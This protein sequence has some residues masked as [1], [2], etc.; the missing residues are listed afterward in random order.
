MAE[1]QDSLNTEYFPD[2]DY[3]SDLWSVEDF[4]QEIQNT[5]PSLWE[6]VGLY[7]IRE[8]QTIYNE[9][10]GKT[11]K[12][13]P[14]RWDEKTRQRLEDN[15][16]EKTRFILDNVI[17][18]HPEYG[19]AWKEKSLEHYMPEF[20]EG[21]GERFKYSAAEPLKDIKSAY[22]Y[23]TIAGAATRLG[24]KTYD[25]LEK[26]SLLLDPVEDP[27]KIE[28]FETE[29][30]VNKD[31]RDKTKKFIELK[32]KEENDRN[33]AKWLESVNR[34]YEDYAVKEIQKRAKEKE[35]DPR[36]RAWSNYYREKPPKWFNTF[37]SKE[38]FTDTVFSM[39]PSLATMAVS[40]SAGGTAA[41]GTFAATKNPVKAI[42]AFGAVSK[43]VN[44]PLMASMEAVDVYPEA[45][46]YVLDKTGDEELARA[47]AAWATSQ[48]LTILAVT[49]LWGMGK[50]S[51]LV[52]PKRFKKEAAKAFQKKTM[53]EM[54]ND[55]VKSSLM[56]KLS[57]SKFA[58]WLTND[59]DAKI[60]KGSFVEGFQEYV[61]YQGNLL[62][63][64]GYKD[65][66]YSELYNPAEASE[67][68]IGGALLG[69][70]FTAASL[71]GDKRNFREAESIL[72]KEYGIET[73]PQLTS[74]IVDNNE[75]IEPI[76]QIGIAPPTNAN[77]I[78]ELLDPYRKEG[79]VIDRTK[80]EG[81]LKSLLKKHQYFNKGRILEKLVD[82]IKDGGKD[83]LD[84]LDEDLKIDMND[85]IKGAISNIN[86][87]VLN[88]VD[89]K[90]NIANDIINNKIS[91][92]IKGTRKGIGGVGI[93]GRKINVTNKKYA[94]K[95]V[96]K[97]QS[98][99]ESNLGENATKVSINNYLST[100]QNIEISK[101][102]EASITKKDA[103]G[104]GLIEREI[105]R[106]AEQQAEQEI[107]QETER[108]ILKKKGI[109][110]FD[111]KGKGEQ[112][113]KAPSV[114]G[115]KVKILKGKY[116][117]IVG[118]I[119]V[120]SEKQ[121][122]VKIKTDDGRSLG[123]MKPDQ[124][125]I[126][127]DYPTP[128]KESVEGETK[129]E[130]KL[131]KKGRTLTYFATTKD[132]GGVKHTTYTF[133]RSDK[134]ESQRNK[135]GVSPETAFGNKYKIKKGELDEFNTEKG[136]N[137]VVD[138]V[139]EVREGEGASADVTLI[140]KATGDKLTDISLILEKT[141]TEIKK[142][143][144]S[145]EETAKIN[146]FVEKLLDKQNKEFE[147]DES[148]SLKV[149]AELYEKY[150]LYDKNGDLPSENELVKIEKISEYLSEIDWT[151]EKFS[152]TEKAKEILNKK[153]L[154][155]LQLNINRVNK[156]EEQVDAELK[157]LE[158]EKSKRTIINPKEKLD[159]KRGWSEMIVD[160][161][162]VSGKNIKGTNLV[163]FK[164]TKGSSK[165]K[166]GIFN[167]ETNEIVAYGRIQSEAIKN[168]QKA[169]KDKKTKETDDLATEDTKKLKK[170]LTLSEEDKYK[171]KL[172]SL[173]KKANSTLI[174]LQSE[175]SKPKDTDIK[176]VNKFRNDILKIQDK[177]EL[178]YDK[179]KIS[180][181][182]KASP[183]ANFTKDLNLY[184]R[185][186]ASNRFK[187]QFKSDDLK[188][189]MQIGDMYEK[190]EKLATKKFIADA[191]KKVMGKHAPDIESTLVDEIDNN[192]NILG[193][194]SE[195]MVEFVL[196]KAT[197]HTAYHEPIHWFFNRVLDSNDYNKL[198]EYFADKKGID[199]SKATS[200]ED[201][202]RMRIEAEEEATRQAADYEL[203]K[204]DRNIAEEILAILKRFWIKVKKFL[205]MRISDE[206]T[207]FDIFERIG[208]D[209]IIRNNDDFNSENE[210]SSVAEVIEDEN[211]IPI[212]ELLPIALSRITDST[213]AEIIDNMQRNRASEYIPKTLQNKIMPLGIPYLKTNNL[214]TSLISSN[215]FLGEHTQQ[216]VPFEFQYGFVN[217]LINKQMKSVQLNADWFESFI[218]EKSK[219][220]HVLKIFE[221][222]AFKAFYEDVIKPEID[223]GVKSIDVVDLVPMY[224][225]YMKKE[226]PLN[227]ISIKH[228]VHDYEITK[229]N[230]NFTM[231][232]G[233]QSLLNSEK[234]DDDW[235]STRVMM[236]NDRLYKGQG[237]GGWEIDDQLS[238]E[239]FNNRK[240]DMGIGWYNYIE[241]RFINDEESKNLAF[242]YEIQ[243]DID[244][245]ISGINAD[246]SQYKAPIIG[247]PI[248]Y[249]K[250]IEEG[251]LSIEDVSWI[252][253]RPNAIH[254]VNS[255]EERVSQAVGEE[256]LH[257]LF[258]KSNAYSSPYSVVFPETKDKNKAFW[259]T[260]ANKDDLF[261]R[262]VEE[263]NQTMEMT[264]RQLG[265]S[266]RKSKVLKLFLPIFYEMTSLHNKNPE[267]VHRRITKLINHWNS[268]QK[269]LINN[270]L[271]P[272]SIPNQETIRG[273]RNR[274]KNDFVTNLF[275]D[276]I[277]LLNTNFDVAVSKDFEVKGM[278]GWRNDLSGWSQIDEI[279]EKTFLD[280]NKIVPKN[281]PS[282]KKVLTILNISPKEKSIILNQVDKYSTESNFLEY[283]LIRQ[284]IAIL[285]ELIGKGVYLSYGL[286]TKGEM[287]KRFQIDFNGVNKFIGGTNKFVRKKI[288]SY[289]NSVR[290]LSNRKLWLKRKLD[291]YRTPD[292][293][294]KRAV[295]YVNVG[296]RMFKGLMK[297]QEF[298]MHDYASTYNKL[299]LEQISPKHPDWKILKKLELELKEFR[300]LQIEHAIRLAHSRGN[301]EFGFAGADANIIMEQESTKFATTSRIYLNVFELNDPK[302]AKSY[303]DWKAMGVSKSFVDRYFGLGTGNHLKSDETIKSEIDDLIKDYIYKTKKPNVQPTHYIEQL[304]EIPFSKVSSDSPRA[305]VSIN[306][307]NE[308]YIQIPY[309]DDIPIK[310]R[311][312]KETGKFETAREQ[313]ENYYRDMPK[314]G[315][316]FTE[317]RKVANKYGLKIDFKSYKSLKSTIAVA[318]LP[319]TLKEKKVKRFHKIKGPKGWKKWITDIGELS[320]K[321]GTKEK[322]T[323]IDDT[324]VDDTVNLIAAKN[325]LDKPYT[326]IEH[327][328]ASF[329]KIKNKY[330][331]EISD[332]VPAVN[333]ALRAIKDKEKRNLVK[334]WLSE[335]AVGKDPQI[336]SKMRSD[337][338]ALN[339][340]ELMGFGAKK[341]YRLK[342]E[343]ADQR[344]VES[345]IDALDK[346]GVEDSHD[347][348]REGLEIS[349]VSDTEEIANNMTFES[350]DFRND[351]FF[352]FLEGT[353]SNGWL[354]AKQTSE[355]L[356]EVKVGN[357]ETTF[358]PYL[359]KTFGF[360]PN[361][362]LENNMVRNFWVRNQPINRQSSIDKPSWWWANL[363][364]NG[365]KISNKNDKRLIP[366][367]G[368]H[369]KYGKDIR[370]NKD[371]P[372]TS[373]VSFIDWDNKNYTWMSGGEIK[374]SRMFLKDMVDVFVGSQ[375]K[376]GSR[377]YSKPMYLT[378]TGSL[379]RS[380]DTKF[381]MFADD[382]KGKGFPLT[383]VDVKSGG[384]S[385][386]F[387]IARANKDIM[388]IASTSDKII[389][390][391]QNE[392]DY[393][394]ITFKMRDV[395]LDSIVNETEKSKLNKYIIAQHITR[396]EVMK[397]TRGRDYMM[398]STNQTHHSRRLAIDDGD[399]IVAVGAGD[400]T[401][402][403]L[404][405]SKL[406]V[407]KGEP[408]AATSSKKIPM[409]DYVAGLPDKYHGDGALWVG[410]DYLDKTAEAIGRVPISPMSSK[411]REIKSRIRWI[412]K[413]DDFSNI[414]HP[415]EQSEE[416][417]GTHYVAFKSNE[418]VP[419]ENI[420]ITDENDNI[421]VYTELQGS[422]IIIRDGEDNQLDMFGTLDEAKEPDGGSGS[423]KLNG[424]VATD[425]LTLPEDSRRIVKIPKQTG[426][427]SAAFPWM[428][429]SHL[430]DS[431]FDSL[432]DGIIDKMLN[433]A[434]SNMNAMFSARK[435]PN[436]MRALMGQFKSD[437]LSIVN[438]V[439]MLLEP[440]PGEM[441]QDGFMHPHLMT[442][443]V[444]PIK[445]KMIKEN[446]YRARR[447]GFGSY[448]VIKPDITKSLVRSKE[449]VVIS[450]DDVTMVRFL[451]DILN[452]SGFNNDLINNINESLRDNPIYV[453]AGRWPT[454]TQSSVFLA[455]VEKVMPRGHGSV[456]WFHPD[457][458]LGK[459]QADNDGDNAFLL[460]MYFGDRYKDRKI[461][462]MLKSKNI[463]DEF[464]KR[465]QFVR[466][467]YFS[468]KEDDYHVGK[469]SDSYVSAGRLGRGINSQGIMMN[470]IDFMENM[471]YKELKMKIGGQSIVVRDPDKINRVMNYA[472]LNDDVTQEMLDNSK[473]GKL[474]DKNGIEWESGDKYLMTSPIIELRILLQAA[475]DNA[476]YSYLSD[477]GFSGYNYLIPKMFVQDNG[478]QIGSKQAITISSLIRKELMHNVLRRGVD[479]TTKKSQTM[480]EMF[481][482]SKDIYDLNELSG[483]DKGS[484]IMKR[485]NIRRLK[486]GKTSRLAKQTL[487]IE[488]ITFNNKLTAMEQLL[489][490][491]HESLL[492]YQKENPNDLVYEHPF[493]YTRNRITRAI[494]QTQKDLYT[495]QSKESRWYPEVGWEKEKQVARN[496]ANHATGEFHR[497]MMSARMHE[498]ITKSRITS[499]GYPYQ[500][501]ILKFIDKWLN[502]GDK[503]KGIP[504]FLEMSK[505]Q[506]AYSTLRFLR[507]TLKFSTKRSD[508]ITAREEQLGNLIINLREK[509]LDPDITE[510][511][512]V[513]IESKIE[514]H[515]NTLSKTREPDSW[516]K[517]GRARDIEKMLP[518]P[519]MHPDVWSEYINRFGPNLR[520]A[521][522][523]KIRLSADARYEDS[524]N[525]TYEQLMKGCK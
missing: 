333:R 517:M 451:K 419:E 338:P 459:L 500:D 116:K 189:Y 407:S 69:G 8:Y 360:V 114:I 525:K 210:V 102:I 110:P 417:E 252:Q 37:E 408:G 81:S 317:F 447:R 151:I 177:I 180:K 482:S 489:S 65:E 434:R 174:K 90:N 345:I 202:N 432:R 24:L 111:K 327:F 308:F 314:L 294:V 27:I 488:S 145:K 11:E 358:L 47:Q 519:L 122:L 117:D 512:K 42:A 299:L 16:D 185:D 103:T 389:E 127:P 93:K 318:T 92:I 287:Q 463:K 511:K 87:D 516:L 156:I 169:I 297:S 513:E 239:D 520:E 366:K 206:E 204:M 487:K 182:L 236:T 429:V 316:M 58:N 45:Y 153:E 307:K 171:Q 438:E 129:V 22:G 56:R 228:P 98:N 310:D 439:D 418:F 57:Q 341:R 410:S 505:E 362:T 514:T 215:S 229:P 284:T 141:K 135:G 279:S 480:A 472:K 34:H 219:N 292:L 290:F 12:I 51:R 191:L 157:R 258:V 63:Q 444:E 501:E 509:L 226:F 357:Y 399:G 342:R 84:N 95:L 32:P 112:K 381:A 507:G 453:L 481:Q 67:S 38:Y 346:S 502:K 77:Y 240:I 89:D 85:Y 26:I 326:V 355:L 348:S 283:H 193:A 66:T 454:Y 351:S 405:Q 430:Y 216:M 325:K 168:S 498:D 249:Q 391:Y 196:G 20:W 404:D 99:I 148:P 136:D 522:N 354:S 311:T 88:I 79:V 446:S 359:E 15:P 143:S 30:V 205:N 17:F 83:W 437:G 251:S 334:N 155:K 460:A 54:L 510:D 97:Y 52:I 361:T 394:N 450:G 319:D 352:K 123:P 4:S 448:P 124:F 6:Q 176:K 2:Y 134:K 254:V 466:L 160:N 436:V 70:G 167:T 190:G 25:T 41:L 392:V 398:R 471:F 19:E 309:K 400:F 138:K 322:A 484:E 421:I 86:K 223:K 224:E 121:N 349:D 339:F 324:I 494:M 46:T 456:V 218:R 303:Y 340:V 173:I 107:I 449:G 277:P 263:Q 242:V 217:H 43:A 475:V 113:A 187:E 199:F 302:R 271:R 104:Q 416:I 401:V 469:K 515:Q 213:R 353:I 119:S 29:E 39:I 192:S 503:K 396:H 130:T 40:F 241:P 518:M 170:T 172:H 35:K 478:S 426:H 427:N 231:L 289:E 243:R 462:N 369:P 496:F 331:I 150:D 329:N 68:I 468:K 257:R 269:D 5:M 347:I 455:K 270:K 74:K 403:I 300:R 499:S 376:D 262:F 265:I 166:Y 266:M 386:S 330:G 53:D 61:Q 413:N 483:K 178:I 49:E 131:D 142:E 524:N 186:I 452:V 18:T 464:E 273:L 288:V 75:L 365:N 209:F 374:L 370:S 234:Y 395:I 238:E 523:E 431:S 227:A 13:Y 286:K 248:K 222:E 255:Q 323:A 422:D 146:Q 10:T 28:D 211:N 465:D 125:V 368:G 36:Y 393:G 246:E 197:R 73:N 397:R 207:I 312:N 493:G 175:W 149:E 62:T 411:L 244:K 458:A 21:L 194:Y 44:L 470:S 424:R 375:N 435:D 195:G 55:P 409:A 268:L 100:Q 423:F 440:K 291:L 367:I 48:Y 390:Y 380:F 298:Q 144:F 214:S 364:P 282:L 76:E 335:W 237:H 118:K 82:V 363:D 33:F 406:F 280:K 388:D 200:T 80:A 415:V 109:V 301:R 445:N 315:P 232:Y 320:G 442:G 14:R 383:I 474:V 159:H 158:K 278:Q 276:Q 162:R 152:I 267:M 350:Y 23:S 96:K 50:L 154:K 377:Y 457:T 235:L 31:F 296:N 203:G 497:I 486:F 504:S 343:I 295:D 183:D 264:E 313:V 233:L 1:N 212:F 344:M 467:E 64:L 163:I 304:F 402:K 250:L 293:L 91:I 126:L 256:V 120:Y 332:Y 181:F 128:P 161:R 373:N 272:L 337:N 285:Y 221:K 379:L 274:T 387:I 414:H 336:A 132:K 147:S 275:G 78:K 305:Y 106:Q 506:Q 164:N 260:R 508:K 259:L 71:I 179:E 477:W 328:D 139:F 371:L 225:D 491:P 461:V 420:Y 490:I 372:K 165:E 378:V 253:L 433:V 101:Q 306:A 9:E 7:D 188:K 321:S 495:I 385:P 281:W 201:L 184:L 137:W 382:S 60:L 492:K 384:N 108:E 441:I 443:V 140:N 72:N 485:A 208:R 261:Y 59:Y 412:S 479:D 521:S 220:D 115:K 425:T 428:W 230:V 473:M 247:V 356:D 245:K 94:D 476:S 3:L 198:I 133:N 105:Q